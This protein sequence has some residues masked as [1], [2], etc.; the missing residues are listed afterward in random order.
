MRKSVSF[1]SFFFFL[2]INPFREN[3]RGI[4]IGFHTIFAFLNTNAEK[5]SKKNYWI[6]KPKR[7]KFVY[8]L[9]ISYMAQYTVT[10]TNIHTGPSFV[11]HTSQSERISRHIEIIFEKK[12]SLLCNESSWAIEFSYTVSTFTNARFIYE[13]ETK[14]LHMTFVTWSVQP[15]HNN[16]Y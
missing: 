15:I 8:K 7:N 6:I 12:R 10:I 16:K 2:S 11:L 5:K 9:A 13:S 3:G 1:I 14:I 4:G